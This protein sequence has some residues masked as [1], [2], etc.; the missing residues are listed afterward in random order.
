MSVLSKHID[1][2]LLMDWQSLTLLAVICAIA[3][4]F[5]KDYLANP[6]LVIFIYPILL[7]FSVLAQYFFMQAELYSPKKLD[8]WLMWTIMASLV[9]TVIGTGLVA[10]IAALRDRSDN[11]RA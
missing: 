8:Q 9:G 1:G 6:I 2:L 3:A 11:R 4:F 10:G 7:F 5:I